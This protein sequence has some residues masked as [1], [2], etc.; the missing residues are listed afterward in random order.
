[1]RRKQAKSTILNSLLR[2]Q[3]SAGR[4][5]PVRVI[6]DDLLS[7]LEPE[8][9]GYDPYDKSPPPPLDEHE[10]EATMERRLS[11]KPAK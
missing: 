7:I 5:A 4:R 6:R 3:G 10:V 1:M 11:R 8:S 2:K 9:R